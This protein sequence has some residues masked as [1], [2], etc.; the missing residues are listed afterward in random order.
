MSEDRK[1][2]PTDFKDVAHHYLRSGIMVQVWRIG[3]T[4][5]DGQQYESRGVLN[6]SHLELMKGDTFVVRPELKPMESMTDEQVKAMAVALNPET[7]ELLDS[8]EHRVSSG[9]VGEWAIEA[10]GDTESAPI[11]WLCAEFSEVADYLRD[12]GYDVHGLIKSGRATVAK[13]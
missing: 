2:K 1:H 7:K 13:P 3:K 6:A 4:Y 11:A 12:N 5:S 8:L 10:V 9:I